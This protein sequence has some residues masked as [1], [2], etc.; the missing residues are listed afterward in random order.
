MSRGNYKSRLEGLEDNTFNIGASSDPAKFSKLLKNIETYIQKNYKSPDDI[1][2]A[3]PQLGQPTLDYPAMPSKKDYKDEDGN[4]D[5]VAFKMAVFAWKEDYKA[6]RVRKDRY[7]DNESNAW[8]LVYYQCSP[9]LK[10]KL[11][12]AEG[13]DEAKETNN[14]IQLLKMIRN[15]CC[16]FNTLN[17]EYVL[18]VGAFKNLFF[19][20]QKPDQANID[21]HE[22]FMAL[23]KVI[24][25]YGGPRSIT[26]FQT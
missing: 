6:M 23:V 5:L 10:K 18:I 11:E 13:Y 22:D 9:E 14:I 25:E 16:Q 19:F 3:L 1:V 21:Y 7:R 20:W 4:K 26:H 24:E 17:N 8:A 2:K 15:Y 12:R